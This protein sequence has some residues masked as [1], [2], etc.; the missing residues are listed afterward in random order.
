MD[1]VI[2][3]DSDSEMLELDYRQ[4]VGMAHTWRMGCSTRGT[5]GAPTTATHDTDARWTRP[6]RSRE[7]DSDDVDDTH[8]AYALPLQRSID[9]RA[10]LWPS[11]ARERDPLPSSLFLFLFLVL[12]YDLMISIFP[13]S[14]CR[15]ARVLLREKHTPG[16]LF[17]GRPIAHARLHIQPSCICLCLYYLL[18][19]PH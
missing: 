4:P 10:S 1:V 2:D 15:F 7:R 13:A 8:D 11:R 6:P 12:G 18:L 16:E 5:D 17:P 14:Q 3:S 19:L 9:H